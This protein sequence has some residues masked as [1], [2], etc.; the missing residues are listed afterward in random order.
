MPYVARSAATLRISGEF[1]DP[2]EISAQLGAAP[3]SSHMKGDVSRTRSGHEIVRKVGLWRLKATDR[4][5][6][7]IDVQIRDLLSGLTQDLATWRVLS[8]AYE[9]DLFCGL[10][11]DDSNEGL[12]LSSGSLTALADRGV[13]L[14]FDIYAPVRAIR[15]DEACPCGSGRQYGECCAPTAA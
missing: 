15:S 5:P 4:V 1:L 2:A 11:M 10:F 7:D 12:E 14:G 3:T 8:E 13:K 9:V 6:E